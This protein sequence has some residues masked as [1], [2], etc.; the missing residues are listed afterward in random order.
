MADTDTDTDTDTVADTDAVADT[1]IVA[2][3]D[4]V[5]DTDTVA[6]TDTKKNWR[7]RPLL[8]TAVVTLATT[9]SCVDTSSSSPAA[10]KVSSMT[11][12][13]NIQYSSRDSWLGHTLLFF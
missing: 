3:T 9:T 10:D 4:A 5:A 2:D 11:P 7:L 13:T 1:D 12:A 8:R 6:N